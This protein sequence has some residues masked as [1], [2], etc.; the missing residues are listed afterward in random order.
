MSGKD[1]VSLNGL[2]A[3]TASPTNPKPTNY[4]VRDQL[5]LESLK[6]CR[7]VKDI[8]SLVDQF[9]LDI[10]REPAYS[11]MLFTHI[12]A[13]STHECERSV[14]DELFSFLD[15][16]SLN[17]QG[18]GNYL[19]LV[20]Y[21]TLNET[22]ASM[23][24]KF[25]RLIS[26]AL[27]LGLIPNTEIGLIIKTLPKIKVRSGSLSSERTGELAS[28]YREIWGALQSCSIQSFK[29]LHDV[30]EPL[31]DQLSV[32]R[33][34]KEIL[35]LAKDIV[36]ATHNS[37]STTCPW[38][39]NFIMQWIGYSVNSASNETCLIDLDADV[40]Y[41]CELLNVLSAD[42]AVDS[43]IQTSEILA[44]SA[45]DEPCRRLLLT[46]WRDILLHIPNA[47]SLAHSPVWLD[48]KPMGSQQ[49]EHGS[50]PTLASSFSVH[51][52]VLLRLWVLRCF[53][54]SLHEGVAWRQH[55]KPT[56]STISTLLNLFD[57]LNSERNEAVFFTN[58]TEGL[59]ELKLPYNGVMIMA[60]DFKTKK[61]ATK[62]AK[63]IFEQL[64]RSQ[65]TLADVAVD[66]YS[67]NATKAHYFPTFEKMIQ[68]IDI[69][70]PAFVGSC[71]RL[72]E[73]GDE[74]C[75]DLLRLLRAHTPLKIA[76]AMS[77]LPPPD[78]AQKALVTYRSKE[79]KLRTPDPHLCL[80]LIHLLAIAIS[81][82]TKFK[83]PDAFDMVHWLYVFLKR[84]SAP[85][86]P[87]LIRAMYH[88]GVV[89]YRREGRSVSRRRY[90]YILSLVKRFEDPEVVGF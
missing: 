55:P 90:E 88:C 59:Q 28:C 45:K 17:P 31:L 89:R 53:S 22:S 68:N 72:A 10:A 26:R 58:L 69:T 7:N 29:D 77:W 71:I 63:R 57:S 2:H 12:L 84:H 36:L 73:M 11:Q 34:D 38:V 82:S 51:Q 24:F 67:F 83:A 33:P 25:L 85:I 47:A 30:L 41:V 87:S 75:E 6:D 66:L 79:A 27:E 13:Q 52:R 5:L 56:D 40:E 15:E 76:L 54:K 78:P 21:L 37:M 61:K 43:I 20:E 70:S 80:Q 81:T 16:P 46:A 3:S 4:L 18:A 48:V 39:P 42:V 62:I 65:I 32:I 44:F 9:H 50:L 74:G 35:L 1:S 23:R 19:S 49:S 60:V 86:K 8:K 14:I 64:E